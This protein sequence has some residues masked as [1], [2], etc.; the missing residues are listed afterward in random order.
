MNMCVSELTFR[1]FGMWRRAVLSVRYQTTHFLRVRLWRWQS[2]SFRD[3][4][5]SESGLLYSFVRLCLLYEVKKK[6]PVDT[7]SVRPSVRP[8]VM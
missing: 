8:S 3:C 2:R 6:P 5:V 7:T 4:W 1:Y